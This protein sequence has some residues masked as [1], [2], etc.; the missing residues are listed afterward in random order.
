MLPLRGY[1]AAPGMVSRSESS[2]APSLQLAS[3]TLCATSRRFCFADPELLARARSCPRQACSVMLDH[4]T[5]MA[6]DRPPDALFGFDASNK[7][8]QG[9]SPLLR[10]LLQRCPERILKA[11]AGVAT[12]NSDRALDHRRS[13]WLWTPFA[14]GSFEI[15]QRASLGCGIFAS[16]GA[17]A[18]TWAFIALVMEEM[19]KFILG[20]GSG[21][22]DA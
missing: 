16:D 18:S 3:A 22:P 2:E 12:I 1:A 14:P 5:R 19:T 21:D 20:L 17:W 9:R 11:H 4:K 6:Y 10:I 7:V 13:G 8:L 15:P